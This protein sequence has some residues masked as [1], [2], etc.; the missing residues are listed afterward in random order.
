[1]LRINGEITTFIDDLE[2]ENKEQLMEKLRAFRKTPNLAPN[3]S[4][5]DFYS[6]IG[7]A[8]QQ[9]Y[10]TNPKQIERYKNY[11]NYRKSTGENNG[12]NDKSSN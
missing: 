8:I 12:R 5:D 9:A 1:M 7:T 11:C 4:Y 2:F 3:V 10:Y 6:I